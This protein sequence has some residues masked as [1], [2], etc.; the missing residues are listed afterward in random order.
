MKPTVYIPDALWI[1]ARMLFP[2]DNGSGLATRAF[3]ALLRE[4]N[5]LELVT[6]MERLD[7][8]DRERVESILDEDG[9]D[10]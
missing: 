2:T 6:I 1:T 9:D 5:G 4:N 10:A 8:K 7:D 3:G